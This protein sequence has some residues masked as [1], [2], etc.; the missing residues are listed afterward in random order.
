VERGLRQADLGQGRGCSSTSDPPAQPPGAAEHPSARGTGSSRRHSLC[1]GRDTART[2]VPHATALL[3]R[4]DLFA[5]P[6]AIASC[7]YEGCTAQ[8]PT[9]THESNT[10]LTPLLIPP[11]GA[12]TGADRSHGRGLHRGGFTPIAGP[13]LR[14][15]PICQPRSEPRD[16]GTSARDPGLAGARPRQPRTHPC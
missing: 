8:H 7:L 9:T 3:P 14:V 12:C 11:R 6:R 16:L 15:C 1:T 2:R 10:A 5:E 4:G 13:L